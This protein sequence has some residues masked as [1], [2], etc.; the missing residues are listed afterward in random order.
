MYVPCVKLIKNWNRIAMASEDLFGHE[1]SEDPDSELQINKVVGSR[2]QAQIEEIAEE[3]EEHVQNGK[4]EATKEISTDSVK[5]TT[6]PETK[7]CKLPMSR[8]RNLMKL[9]PDLQVASHEAVF[10]VA[11]SVELFIESLARES[12]TYTAQAKKKTVQKRDVELAIAAVD[13]LMFLD[14]AINF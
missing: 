8:I 2:G 3:E 14:G 6:E 11:R 13:C 4:T 10:A 9:D 5:G 1:Y 7:L 12:Y